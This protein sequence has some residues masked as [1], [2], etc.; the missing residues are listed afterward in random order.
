[1][2]A[3]LL[4]KGKN[5]AFG[6]LTTVGAERVYIDKVWLDKDGEVERR[7]IIADLS[8]ERAAGWAAWILDKTG[9]EEE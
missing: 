1:M 6:T 7:E 9:E 5:K 8:H 3:K 2:A 4:L